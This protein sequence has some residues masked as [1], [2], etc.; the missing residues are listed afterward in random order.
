M[1]SRVL[2]PILVALSGLVLLA[3]CDT[4]TPDP[5]PERGPLRRLTYPLN[6]TSNSGI[7]PDGVRG[8]V[9]IWE[10][11]SQTSIVTL[12]LDNGPT[13]TDD[14][15]VAY[16]RENEAATGGDILFRLTP[17][18]GQQGEGTSAR[19][20]NA[21]FDSLAALDGHV[22]L[23]ERLASLETVIAQGDIGANANGTPGEG[24]DL[25]P[26]PR[27]IDYSLTAQ[28]NGGPFPTGVS[29][30]VLF[31]ELS[32]RQTLATLEL[33]LSGATGADVSHPAFIRENTVAEGGPIVLSLA[34]IDG[35]DP[36]VRSS[37]ILETPID[38]LV[39]FNGHVTVEQS[40]AVDT[41]LA[42]GN[43]GG[44]AN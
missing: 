19:L 27:G 36:A 11:S 9:T 12:A 8:T 43:I 4:N 14:A 26:R 30:R 42:R 2:W 25:P 40:V 33:R 29:G 44:N 15:H 35:S 34:P 1:V 7:L 31:Q 10:I 21:S 24:F 22:T 20:V 38:S 32:P 28:V 39:V 5:P 17:I 18:N 23:H 13:G 37:Q 6:P 16:L 41:V 3:G